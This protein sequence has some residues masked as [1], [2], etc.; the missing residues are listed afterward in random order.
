[1][2]FLEYFTFTNIF[3]ALTA[4]IV[5]KLIIIPYQKSLYYTK[6]GGLQQ[7]FP[8]LGTFAIKARDLK[9]HGDFFYGEK[10]SLRDHPN[11]QFSVTNFGPY[12][13]LTLADLD[14]I[15][16]LYM[17]DLECYEKSKLI[18]GQR[19]DL[20]GD[21]MATAEGAV[22]KKHRRTL[23]MIFHY[24]FM[25]S[26]IP[27]IITT[28][29]EF[30]DK[31]AKG[32]LKKVNIMDHYHT[33]TGEVVGRIFFGDNLNQYTF[34]GELLTLS[35]ATLMKDI[36]VASTTLLK[37]IIGDKL[38]RKTPAMRRMADKIYRFRSVCQGIVQHRKEARAN[39]KR[40]PDTKDLLDLLLDN[41]EMS[42]TEI[43][44]EFVSFFM[45]GMDTT[46]HLVIMMTYALAKYPEYQV[47]IREE[48]Q[49]VYTG[50]KPE[51]VTLESLKELSTMDLV[52]KET[53]RMW[54][55]TPGIFPREAIKDHKLGNINVKKGTI[56]AI[57][58]VGIFSSPKYWE[59][60]DRF[61]P[62]RWR[63]WE[64]TA[65][66]RNPYSFI[67]FSA[68]ARNCIGQH[69]AMMEAKIIMAEFLNKFEYKLPEDYKLK[70][71]FGFLVEPQDPIL[72]NLTV[73]E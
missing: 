47:Q 33:I 1:M 50:K 6:Q 42:D 5:V 19:K 23:S 56:V 12:I 31:L 44:D 49:N 43:I 39:G 64:Q 2:V 11:M 53:L 3:L 71:M 4:Y 20:L 57:N 51:E 66:N 65:M 35:L 17:K 9:K 52:L 14:L 69:L 60:P 22:W 62:E 27:L 13:F 58:Q 36:A 21:G 18:L 16:E 28:T 40:N 7:F 73:R 59:E 15:K 37:L 10:K 8:L 24:E 61:N 54:N 41:A 46:G 45:A 29:R 25:K 26:K 72:L 55:P 38:Y 48:V 63:N 68:G 30:L 70:M 67:P 34:D 32:D